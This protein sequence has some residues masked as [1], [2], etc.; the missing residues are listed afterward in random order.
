M[1]IVEYCNFAATVQYTF[2][3][4]GVCMCVPSC[5]VV[6]RRVPCVPRVC[7]CACR[8]VLCVSCRVCTPV[9]TFHEF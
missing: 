8:V 9:W 4:L 3:V 5:A 1:E 6:C 2:N 7:V